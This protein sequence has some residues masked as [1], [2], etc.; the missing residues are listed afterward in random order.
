VTHT[1]Y[2]GESFPYADTNI[3]PGNLCTFVGSE[4]GY[5]SDTVWYA[6]CIHDPD[7]HPPFHFDPTNPHFCEQMAIVDEALRVADGRYPVSMPDL[8][9]NMDILAAMRDPQTLMFDLIERPGWVKERIDA[10]NPIY[11]QAFDQI[12]A[13]IQ[14]EFGGNVY[15]AFSVWG[16]G[17]TAKLQCDASAMFSPQMYARLV[18]PALAEQCR[19]LD[20]ALYH[21]DGTQAVCQLNNL[22]GIERLNAI[23][24]TPQ[25]GLPG[26]GSPRWYDLYRRILAAGKGVQAV[27]VEYDE[28]IP[29][30][31]AV[32]PKGLYIMTSAPS[33]EA[34]RRLEERVERYR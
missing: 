10:L 32:G 33:E 1:Y 8:V 15:T 26:G 13:R 4:P 29:L 21:L 23:E 9:E 2:A 17:R 30:L 28:V 16:P 3:G 27:G 31:D 14:D 24:W 5:A 25:A 12:F 6:A 7:N 22:L 18:A 34:A 11:Y 19:W 20:Y